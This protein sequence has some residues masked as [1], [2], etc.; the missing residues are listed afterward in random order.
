[1]V[2]SILMEKEN[3]STNKEDARRPFRSKTLSL[4]QAQFKNKEE[5]KSN[6]DRYHGLVGYIAG[7][8]RVS[9]K[10]T[11]IKIYRLQSPSPKK[12]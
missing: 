5:L 8:Y 9:A 7:L 6:G 12:S 2:S 4:L 10:C 1:M 3:L 11:I